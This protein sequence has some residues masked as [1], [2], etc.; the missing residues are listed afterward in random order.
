ME[1][2]CVK[3]M[4][5]LKVVPSETNLEFKKGLAVRKCA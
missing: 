1:I 2:L 3:G 4:Y 5:M